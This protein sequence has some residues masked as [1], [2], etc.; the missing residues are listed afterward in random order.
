MAYAYLWSVQHHAPHTRDEG[1]RATPV[2]ELAQVGGAELSPPQ[3]CL[4]TDTARRRRRQALAKDRRA[5]QQL[6]KRRAVQ[7]QR[8]ESGESLSPKGFERPAF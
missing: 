3:V 5:A 4:V 6:V 7:V 2:E 1:R 8:S